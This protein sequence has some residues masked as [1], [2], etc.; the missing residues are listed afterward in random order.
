MNFKELKLRYNIFFNIYNRDCFLYPWIFEGNSFAGIGKG[1]VS[2]LGEARY[3]YNVI[4]R[5]KDPSIRYE[6]IEF[7]DWWKVIIDT[8]Y[9]SLC[10]FLG[11]KR[12]GAFPLDIEAYRKLLFKNSKAPFICGTVDSNTVT[13]LCERCKL[14]L[15]PLP[16]KAT[17][18]VHK[19]FQPYRWRL[20][21]EV[22]LWMKMQNTIEKI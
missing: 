11:H 17:G 19:V 14:F 2:P 6:K 21:K 15:S 10:L 3:S 13:L 22:F 8:T 16:H 5:K 4:A 1:L 12:A 20:T 7:K 9:E 18:D